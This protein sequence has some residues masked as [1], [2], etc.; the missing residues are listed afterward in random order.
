[1]NYTCTGAM[2]FTTHL[3]EVTLITKVDI[4]YTYS[5]NYTCYIRYVL[6]QKLISLVSL[7]LCIKKGSNMMFIIID[8]KLMVLAHFS[9]MLVHDIIKWNIIIYII[10]LIENIYYSIL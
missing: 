4:H 8:V 3:S 7:T 1:M 10:S 6:L 2:L 9:K 5:T